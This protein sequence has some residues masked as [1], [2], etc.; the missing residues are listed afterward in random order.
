MSRAHVEMTAC[1]TCDLCGAEA[2]RIEMRPDGDARVAVTITGIV[3]VT[4]TWLAAADAPQVAVALYGTVRA[5]YHYNDEWASFFCPECERIYCAKHWRTEVIFED[6]PFPAW[7]DCTYGTCP[8]GHR[9]MVD[10]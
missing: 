3:G 5:L 9:R 1:Y 7:Y 6:D 2:G 10:D 4:Q 8:E